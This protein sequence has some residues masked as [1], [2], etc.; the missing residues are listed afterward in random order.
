MKT[1]TKLEK[2]LLTIALP[3]IDGTNE[4]N[5][6]CALIDSKKLGWSVDTTK[7][8][9]GSLMN[10]KILWDNEGVILFNMIVCD[11]NEDEDQFINTIEKMEKYLEVRPY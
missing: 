6:D 5:F 10:K 3:N 1:L 2:D 8:V 11:D 9:F 4:Y 7:G